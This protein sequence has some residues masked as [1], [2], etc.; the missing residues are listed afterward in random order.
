MQ[1]EIRFTALPLGKRCHVRIAFR[2]E[3]KKMVRCL[4]GLVPIL[5]VVL[6]F[7]YGHYLLILVSCSVTEGC[8]EGR[9]FMVECYR[10]DKKHVKR[11]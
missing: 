1:R 11:L 6:V 4:W 8:D 3:T 5:L 10:C 2:E 9:Y 7:N